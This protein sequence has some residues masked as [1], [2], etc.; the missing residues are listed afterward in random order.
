MDASDAA[1]SEAAVQGA[2]E[3]GKAGELPTRKTAPDDHPGRRN[4]REGW[5][6]RQLP[7]ATI[8]VIGT[9]GRPT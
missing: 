4:W 9:G 8:P 2:G 7:R 6:P 3:P 1:L 5:Q